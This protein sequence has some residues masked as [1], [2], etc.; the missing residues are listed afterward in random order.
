MFRRPLLLLLLG[1]RRLLMLGLGWM[2]WVRFGGWLV[3][4][5]V[6]YFLYGSKKSVLRNT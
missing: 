4:G 3:V 6:I 1:T 2:N 5:L